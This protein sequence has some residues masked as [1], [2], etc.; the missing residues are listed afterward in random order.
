MRA[1]CPEPA[2]PG[3]GE[4]RRWGGSRDPFQW[5]NSYGDVSGGLPSPALSWHLSLSRWK[6]GLEMVILLRAPGPGGV[7]GWFQ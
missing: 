1:F 2:L 3:Q 4:G 6:M 5:V 7:S